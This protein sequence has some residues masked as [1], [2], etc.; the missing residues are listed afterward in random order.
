M[1]RAKGQGAMGL[2]EQ[3]RMSRGAWVCVLFLKPHG[4]SGVVSFLFVPHGLVL[5]RGDG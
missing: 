4:L 5:V 3:A 2:C 1:Q